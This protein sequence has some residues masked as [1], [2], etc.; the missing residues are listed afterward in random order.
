MGV[1]YLGEHTL[2]GRLAAIKVLLPALSANQEIVQRSFNEAR[3]VAQIADPGIVQV[4]DFGQHTDGSAF[5]VMELLQGEPVDRRLARIG[6][7]TPIDCLRLTA[8]ICRSLAAA[9]ARGIVHRDLK[10]ENLFIVGDP[11]VTGGERPK[12]LDFGIAKL[13]SSEPGALKTRT[14]MMMGT[15][16]YM[17]PGYVGSCASPLPGFYCLQQ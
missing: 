5:I 3:A 7:F 12:I 17:S 10:P 13:S 1:V 11:V 16:V 6:R 4:Y 2:L 15:P 9:H 14:G 8:L